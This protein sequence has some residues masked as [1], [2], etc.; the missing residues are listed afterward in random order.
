MSGPWCLVLSNEF[1]GAPSCASL[2]IGH[3]GQSFLLRIVGTPTRVIVSAPPPGSVTWF[4][5]P[6][7]AVLVHLLYIKYL[8]AIHAPYGL[9][10]VVCEDVKKKKPSKTSTLHRSNLIYY[11]AK[12]K[13][14]T[15]NATLMVASPPCEG[16][17]SSISEEIPILCQQRFKSTNCKYSAFTDTN[18]CGDT[19]GSEGEPLRTNIRVNLRYMIWNTENCKA[20]VF[21]SFELARWFRSCQPQC[22]P[23]GRHKV[24]WNC[25]IT[26][27]TC[28]DHTCHVLYASLNL[29]FTLTA[30]LWFLYSKKSRTSKLPPTI[31]RWRHA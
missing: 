3:H 17:S 31:R 4:A 16:E 18:G 19:E 6:I 1:A 7:L 26:M 30:N 24:W 9:E 8:S 11:R 5:L 15:R 23:P 13:I 27:D 25:E 28:D 10:S 29:Y 20:Y 22:Q 12:L 14:E 21:S 2:S